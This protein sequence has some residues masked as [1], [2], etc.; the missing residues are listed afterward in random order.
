MM[1]AYGLYQYDLIHQGREAWY[2]LIKQSLKTDSKVFV[3]IPEYFTDRGIGMYPYLTGSASW[4]LKLLRTEVFGIKMIFGKVYLEP[5]L[6]K[7]DFIDGKASV[8]TYI[9]GKLINITYHN[10]KQ[11][12][13][14]A[15]VVKAIRTAGKIIQN[16]FQNVSADIEVE[17]DEIR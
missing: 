7:D 3:G 6:T 8:E 1:Y 10:P 14:H 12:D 4:L 15:Y 2:T 16:G 11:L 5:K 9:H 17:L 13:A